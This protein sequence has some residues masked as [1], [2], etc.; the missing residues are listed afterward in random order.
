MSA[1]PPK[2]EGGG[3]RN[4]R[5]GAGARNAGPM[6]KE[7]VT[8]VVGLESHIFDIGH[9]KFAAKYQKTVEAIANHI[10]KDYKG[11]PEIAKALRDLSLPVIDIPNYP[12]R[13]GRTVDPG[14]IYLWQEDVKEAKRKIA[15]LKENKKR[16]HALIIGQ[17]SLELVSKIQGSDLYAQADTDQDAVQLLLIIRGYCCSFDA[18]QQSTFTLKGAKHRV[19]VFTQGYDVTVT[20]YVEYFMALVGVVE[21][22]G[23]AY[24]NKPGLL[25]E[26]LIKQGV[27]AADVDKTVANGGPDAAEIK[28]ALVVT[29]ECYLSCMIL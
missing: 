1:L 3:K 25:R 10:Q 28:K 7:Y 22:Y 14:T 2:V 24:G 15:L 11:G 9:A 27:S 6:R 21:T 26:Q 4:F 19:Q 23:G 16:A 12:T 13:I 18:N 20:D 5:K 17:C 29:R 8:K